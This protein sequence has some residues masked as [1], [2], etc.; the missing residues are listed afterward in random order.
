MNYEKIFKTLENYIKIRTELEGHNQ[1]TKNTTINEEIEIKANPEASKE[2]VEIKAD[3]DTGIE[4]KEEAP[5]S[6]VSYLKPSCI[7][8]IL[9]RIKKFKF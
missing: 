8:G 1:D 5:S 7:A 3:Q 6:R 9:A 2:E 4:I